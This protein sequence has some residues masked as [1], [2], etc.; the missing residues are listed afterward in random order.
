MISSSS[1]RKKH[2]HSPPR[3][4]VCICVCVCDNV[5]V[6]GWKRANAQDHSLRW[7]F[8]DI[9]VLK[10]ICL[11]ATICTFTRVC[12][13]QRNNESVCGCAAC[14]GSS[15]PLVYGSRDSDQ[16]Q[17]PLTESEDGRGFLVPP[18]GKLSPCHKLIKSHQRWVESKE[19]EGRGVGGG[20]THTPTPT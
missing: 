17:T 19:Q 18:S 7:S 13:C 3:R 2:T 12:K 9:R 10:C 5:I 14:R 1:L 16:P 15:W 6:L 8:V 20:H 4:H 11:R